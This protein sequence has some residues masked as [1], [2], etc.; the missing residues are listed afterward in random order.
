MTPI[1]KLPNYYAGK[2]Y[3]NWY[4]VNDLHQQS[5]VLATKIN[6]GKYIQLIISDNGNKKELLYQNGKIMDIVDIKGVKR[7]YMY[8]RNNDIVKGQMI[9]A[10]NDKI[11]SPLIEA[12]KWTAKNCMPE[13]L[14]LKL[15]PKHPDSEIFVPVKHLSSSAKSGFDGAGKIIKAKEIFAKDF[16][17]PYN[18]LPKTIIIKDAKGKTESIMAKSS[19]ENMQIIEQL[20]LTSDALGWKLRTMV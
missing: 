5:G 1:H 11:K 18:P 6:K 10:P 12:A 8:T 20:G 3:K 2:L 16:E 19:K 4:A 17:N 15:N 9:V 13:R 7:T 14:F